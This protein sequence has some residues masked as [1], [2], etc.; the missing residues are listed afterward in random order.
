MR[1]R[2][3][4]IKTLTPDSLSSMLD[5][6]ASGYLKSAALTWDAIERRDDVIQAVACK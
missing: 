1:A 2:F 5:G 3:N 6:F 4:P